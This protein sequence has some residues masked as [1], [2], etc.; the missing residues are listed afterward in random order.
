MV[1]VYP[2]IS[3]AFQ[4][5]RYAGVLSQGVVHLHPQQSREKDSACASHFVD[6]AYKKISDVVEET[7][8]G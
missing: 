3:F 8:P 2:E 5:E 7:D 4:R 6:K 1:I